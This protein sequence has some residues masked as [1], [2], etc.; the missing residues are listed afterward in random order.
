MR[1]RGTSRVVAQAVPAVLV[2]LLAAALTLAPSPARADDLRWEFERLMALDFLPVGVVGMPYRGSWT[3]R[4]RGPDG[5]GRSAALVGADAGT[6][7]GAGWGLQLAAD[8]PYGVRLSFAALYHR[9]E[10]LD[11]DLP[12]TAVEDAEHAEAWFGLGFQ[13]QL[14]GVSLH[15]QTMVG[16]DS[17]AFHA[18]VKPDA[19]L[20]QGLG[21]VATP[22]GAVR[23]SR[24]DLRVGQEAGLHV[25]LGRSTLLF[26]SFQ[27]D[28]DGQWHLRIGI[29]IG[30]FGPPRS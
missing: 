11:H 16:L 8:A 4:P 14:R 24:F 5:N 12:L 1:T 26:G 22:L 9:G 6:F 13:H 25:S 28:L 7:A 30:G 10:L 23:V 15:T 2:G 27:L 19:L 21:A 17:T 18:E 29:G 20:V 3:L